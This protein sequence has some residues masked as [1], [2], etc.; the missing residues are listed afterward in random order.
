MPRSKFKF[1]IEK[2][3]QTKWSTFKEGIQST[4]SRI[5][6]NFRQIAR[7]VRQSRLFPRNYRRVPNND[8]TVAHHPEDIEMIQNTTNEFAHDPEE[9]ESLNA[10][11]STNLSVSNIESV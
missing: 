10:T 7:N 6:Q 3:I 4:G 1:R 8:S 11:V 2:G 9:V 5:G